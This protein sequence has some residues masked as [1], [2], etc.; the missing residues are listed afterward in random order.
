VKS[1]GEGLVSSFLPAAAGGRG[2]GARSMM[3]ET[4]VV[5]LFLDLGQ[6]LKVEVLDIDLLRSHNWRTSD[7]S[8]TRVGDRLEGDG[9]LG[10]DDSGRS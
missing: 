8:V 3:G 7:R 10:W 4:H 6:L 2:G 1:V 9:A 5:E